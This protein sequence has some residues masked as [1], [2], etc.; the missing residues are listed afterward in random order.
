MRYSNLDPGN[1]VVRVEVL[2]ELSG[3]RVERSIQ[4]ELTK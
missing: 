1:Y 4:I 3:L 2:D